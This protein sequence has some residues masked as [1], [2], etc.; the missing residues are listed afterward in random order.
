MYTE[1]LYDFTNLHSFQDISGLTCVD[2]SLSSYLYTFPIKE[3]SQFIVRYVE[4]L[5]Y[6]GHIIG[7]C[8]FIKTDSNFILFQWTLLVKLGQQVTEI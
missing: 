6:R 4:V 7:Y 3:N 2:H 8:F 5:V 1:Q